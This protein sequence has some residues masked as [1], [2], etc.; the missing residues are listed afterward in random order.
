[1]EAAA[2]G[3]DLLADLVEEARLAVGSQ[4]H[5]LVLVAGTQE[6]EVG[7]QV[8]V[9]QAERVRQRLGGQDLQL[10]ARV[11]AAQEGVL[12]AAAVADQ[13]GA[14]RRPRGQASR[15]GVR[16]VVAYETGAARVQARQLPGEELRGAGGVHGAQLV[17]RVVKAHIRGR[18]RQGRV[19]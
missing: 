3:P 12:L 7:G 17:P 4:R 2:N 16:H 13:H 15:G 14:L 11:P 10:A 9:Q 8:L 19:V 5:H 1:A 18:T 6:A